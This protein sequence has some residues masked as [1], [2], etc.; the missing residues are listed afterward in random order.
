MSIGCAGY[1]VSDLGQRGNIQDVSRV[2]GAVKDG[3]IEIENAGNEG[4]VA[5]GR[6][7]EWSDRNYFYVECIGVYVDI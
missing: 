1:E 3:P 6:F 4:N 7:S 2:I 5:R